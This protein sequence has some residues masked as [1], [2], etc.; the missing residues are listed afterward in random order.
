MYDMILHTIVS[1]GAT[2]TVF[3]SFNLDGCKVYLISEI[4][5]SN[6]GKNTDVARYNSIV[7]GAFRMFK[8][9]NYADATSVQ[10]N[11]NSKTR[12]LNP[13]DKFICLCLSF[14]RKQ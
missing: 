12:R 14:K 6:T 7:F 1:G 5:I 2:S 4:D 9:S 13:C 10:F 8:I 3:G 11:S